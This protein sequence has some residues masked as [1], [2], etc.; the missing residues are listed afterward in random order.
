MQSIYTHHQSVCMQWVNKQHWFTRQHT[1]APS[2]LYTQPRHTTNTNMLIKTK[3]NLYLYA[4][5][6]HLKYS[7]IT[8]NS[9]FLTIAWWV[10]Q[11][12]NRIIYKNKILIRHFL[13]RSRCFFS[14]SLFFYWIYQSTVYLYVFSMVFKYFCV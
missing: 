10:K 11:Q 9:C 7:Y 5:V 3:L 2:C 6:L 8:R 4:Y 12:Q 14:L 13:S 1:Q